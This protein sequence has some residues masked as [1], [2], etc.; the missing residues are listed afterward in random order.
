[1]KNNNK[2]TSEIFVLECILNTMKK[3]DSMF[4]FFGICIK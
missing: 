3:R 1:M 2:N 4:A